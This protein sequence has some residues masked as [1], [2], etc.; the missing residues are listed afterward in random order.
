MVRV[1]IIRKRLNKLG[2]YIDSDLKVFA[3]FI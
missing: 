1:E 3:G 2:E